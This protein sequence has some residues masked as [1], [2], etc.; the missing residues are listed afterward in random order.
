M[1]NIPTVKNTLGCQGKL[2]CLCASGVFISLSE[3]LQN[4]A[5]M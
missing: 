4:P 1:E 5:G 3:E 2:F